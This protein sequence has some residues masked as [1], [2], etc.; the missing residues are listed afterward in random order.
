MREEHPSR[1]LYLKKLI[2]LITSG[3]LTLEEVHIA[4]VQKLKL[5]SINLKKQ[6]ARGK[7]IE[8]EESVLKIEKAI[9]EIE[10]FHCP[11]RVR[12]GANYEKKE[13]LEK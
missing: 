6:I 3:P 12:G 4:L 10:S 13:V 2:D 9:Y 7:K 1:P 5:K 11:Q 8:N